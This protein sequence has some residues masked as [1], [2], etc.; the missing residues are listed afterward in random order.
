MNQQTKNY[1]L[2]FIFII[3]VA[4]VLYFASTKMEKK[5]FDWNN[6]KA[7]S[8]SAF[9]GKFGSLEQYI[10]DSVGCSVFEAEPGTPPYAGIG[11]DLRDGM[12]CVAEI[13]PDKDF[14]FYVHADPVTSDPLGLEYSERGNESNPR[15][16]ELKNTEGVGIEH[17]LDRDFITFVDVNFDGHNDILVTQATGATGN[18]AYLAFL[19][20]KKTS[21]FSYAEEFSLMNIVPDPKT[22]T[23]RS[24]ATMGAAGMEYAVYLYRVES[25]KPILIEEV[26]QKRANPD[27]TSFEKI[28]RK[29]VKGS[30]Q[31][32][33]S[34]IIN[35]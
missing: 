17:P 28:T 5:T 24:F 34:E 29:L 6:K 11:M 9:S 14:I 18:V 7:P 21:D 30:L 33:S 1:L 23:L 13:S 27:A 26:I 35:L 16:V 3:I 20:D 25:N 31:Q 4:S 19:F 2:S 32:V 8:I 22:K 10:S 12:L 15:Y